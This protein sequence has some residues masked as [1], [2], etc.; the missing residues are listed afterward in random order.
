MLILTDRVWG[1]IRTSLT[2]DEWKALQSVVR[3]RNVSPPT[4]EIEADE[5][6]P[7][8]SDKVIGLIAAHTQWTGR[9]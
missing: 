4:V 2:S 9:C 1:L 5:L 3:A 7:A 8:L 6:D